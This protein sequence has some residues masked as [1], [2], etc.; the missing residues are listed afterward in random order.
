MV[1]PVLQ[2]RI[3]YFTKRIMLP[4]SRSWD[5]VLNYL[6]MVKFFGMFLSRF[7]HFVRLLVGECIH[8]LNLIIRSYENAFATQSLI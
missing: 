7:I 5:D 3:C 8:L 4:Y 6:V 1:R 2:E